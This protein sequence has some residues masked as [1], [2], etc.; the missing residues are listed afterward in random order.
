MFLHLWNTQNGAALHL[1]TLS[2]LSSCSSW[3]SPRSFPFANIILPRKD[4]LFGKSLSA[5]LAFTSLVS[6]SV[7]LPT[8]AT[9]G[10][11]QTRM[12]VFCNNSAKPFGYSPH[13]DSV[14]F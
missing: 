11:M 4:T 1:P 3:V 2:F 13:F 6:L 5:Q 7:F 14:V 9:I 10:V 8:S 12:Q